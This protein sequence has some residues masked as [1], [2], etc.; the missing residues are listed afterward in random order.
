MWKSQ[1]AHTMFL[2]E[3]SGSSGGVATLFSRDLDPT[4]LSVNTSALNRF[5]IVTFEL[6]GEKYKVANLYMPTSDKESDQILIL[7][8]LASFL[9]HDEGE[10]LVIGGDFNLALHQDLDRSG[11][12]TQIFQIENIGSILEIS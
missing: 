6:N 10:F 8:C 1:W 11:I 5:L 9:N 2:T 4:I 3:A 7:D 12:L